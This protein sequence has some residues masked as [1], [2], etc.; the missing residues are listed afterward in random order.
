[1]NTLKRLKSLLFGLFLYIFV[2]KLNMKKDKSF[3]EKTLALL[4]ENGFVK[5]KSSLTDKPIFYKSIYT[6]IYVVFCYANSKSKNYLIHCFDLFISHSKSIKEV[7]EEIRFSDFWIGS[8]NINNDIHL[9]IFD[10]L[11]FINKD[12]KLETQF[13]K[14]D[15]KYYKMYFEKEK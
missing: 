3:I 8:F 7:R 9:R 1:M 13:E 6:D 12:M 10:E 11:M 5:D 2:E 4:E 14:L 15:M